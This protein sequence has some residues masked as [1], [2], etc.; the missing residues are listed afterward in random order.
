MASKLPKTLVASI[1]FS[2]LCF[3][4]DASAASFGGGGGGHFYHFGGGG[5]H[6]GG[7]GGGHM[8]GFGGGHMGGFGGMRFGGFGHFGGARFGHFGGGHFARFGHA[9]FGHFSRYHFGGNRFARNSLLSRGRGQFSQF[10]GGLDRGRFGR[11]AFGDQ[12]AWNRWGGRRWGGFNGWG[13]WGGPIFWPYF[14]GDALSFA[15]WPYDYDDSFWGFDSDLLLASIFWSASPFGLNYAFEPGYGPY[16]GSDWPYDIYGVYGGYSGYRHHRAIRGVRDRSSDYEDKTGS[17]TKASYLEQ[18]CGGL[19]PGVTGLPINRIE[20]IVRPTDSQAATLDDLKSAT[21]AASGV[22]KTSCPSD[23]PLTPISRLD[24]V[25]KRLAAVLQAVQLLRNPLASFYNSLSDEQKQ[26][27]EV[28]DSAN[29]L[30]RLCSQPAESFAQLPIQRIEQVIRP[31]PQQQDAFNE[32]KAAS[33]E[34]ANTMQATCPNERPQT[35]MD[36]LAAVEK[37]IDAMLQ[38]VRKVRDPLNKFYS[39]LSDEQKAQFNTMGPP[40]N[41]LSESRSR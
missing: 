15:F 16:Y 4:S 36:R 33:S 12:V 18:T 37:R 9:H 32:L 35:P 10:R 29:G 5:G 19:A 39:S 38:A 30:A 1:A 14:Y 20:R 17:T 11:N 3:G 27:F 28:H 8:G 40:Q 26:R 25:E 7:F 41:G 22:V 23:V 34:A 6:M 21:A 24:A 31:T 13:G 2:A